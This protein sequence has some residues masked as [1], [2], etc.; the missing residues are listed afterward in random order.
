MHRKM[1]LS[2]LGS[3][4]LCFVLYFFSA[5][6]HET[7]RVIRVG[8]VQIVSHPLIDSVRSGFLDEMKAE[9]YGPSD[10]L[11]YDIQNAQGDFSNARN[12]AQKFVAEQ[13]SMIF[14]IS[15]PCTQAAAKTTKSIPIVFGAVTD[16]KTA[17]LVSDYKH[18]GGNITGVSDL[19]PVDKQ[20]DLFLQIMPGLKSLGVVYNPGESN[21][22][23]AV[24]LTQAAC[25]KRGIRLVTAPIASTAE[26]YQAAQSIADRV[27]AFYNGG[28]NTVAAG[29]EAL[30]KISFETRKPLLASDIGT[31]E[32]GGLAT[33]GTD[34]KN[35]GKS[36]AQLAVRVLRGEDPGAIPIVFYDADTV[37]INDGVARRLG[38]TIPATVRKR[39]A[40]IIP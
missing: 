38:I 7:Q 18:P 32:R 27:D 3:G 14:S 9:G 36:G 30:V 2:A 4:I 1:M 19:F 10:K 12:I 26:I 22:K 6:H 37:V 28:D 29:L 15:T 16:P 31:V 25:Q 17:G 33:F 23:V 11:T 40:R 39:A 21:S 13:V 35:V 20:L 24:S 34:Y 5:C 8:V